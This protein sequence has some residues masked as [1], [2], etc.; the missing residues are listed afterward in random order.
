M[1]NQIQVRRGFASLWLLVN[2]V[3]AE[4]EIG[5]EIDTRKFKFGNGSAAWS[6][7]PYAVTEGGGGGGGGATNLTFTRDASTLT[8]LSDT[9]SD[10][11]LPAASQTLAGLMSAADKVALDNAS[12]LV[13]LVVTDATTSRILSSADNG[14]IIR[15]TN[16]GAITV[17][18]SAAFSGFTCLIEW[19]DA[20]GTITI[21]PS[22]TSING[23][24]SPIV[25]SQGRGAVALTPTGTSNT[26]DLQGSIGDLLAA[27]ISDSSAIGRT[28]I[29]AANAA[30]ARTALGLAVGVD[31]QAYSAV[32]SALASASANGQSLVSAADYS[33][34]RTLLSLVPGTNVQAYD[35]ELAALAGLTGAADRLPYF[36][37]PGAA[38]LTTLSAFART[39][40]DDADAATMRATIGAAPLAVT[41]I[42]DTTTART[43]TAADNGAVIRFTNSGPITV[44]VNAGFSGSACRLVKAAGAGNITLVA[45]GTT[46]NN[47]GVISQTGAW[48]TLIPTGTANVFDL[49]G[50]IGSSG[51][52]GV[53]ANQAVQWSG[54]IETVSNKT[55]RL[56]L[57]AAFAVTWNEI[58]VKTASGTCS[59]QATIDGTNMTG[60]SVNATSAEASSTITAANVMAVGQDL[61]IVITSNSTA[62]DLQVSLSGTRVLA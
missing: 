30:A 60:G 57:K 39:L 61:A 48:A 58:T 42:T 45:S 47:N 3:L 62:L 15:F 20:T 13:P 38:A 25:L 41:V 19:Q 5:L 55:Y 37:G 8:V 7:L 27:D 9:G 53:S 59:V 11:V 23:S 12:P 50:Q 17:T 40:L 33:A 22:G 6:A 56:I 28:L 46:I 18:V 52:G 34:M 51:G 35:A 43:L 10:A 26:F 4:G 16:T 1:P 54:V 49:V 21:A 44:T 32:L 14:K 2:P 31:V 36:T 24:G 29:T